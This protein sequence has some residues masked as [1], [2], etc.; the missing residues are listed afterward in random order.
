[1][2]GFVI[3]ASGLLSA[4]RL[5]NWSGGAWRQNDASPWPSGGQGLAMRPLSWPIFADA[6]VEKTPASEVRPMLAS[7]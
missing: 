2:R 3:K 1:L 4:I 6:Q 5:I 7:G